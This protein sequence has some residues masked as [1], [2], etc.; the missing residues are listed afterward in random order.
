[1]SP[2]LVVLRQL[3][4]PSQEGLCTSMRFRQSDVH[5]VADFDSRDGFPNGQH[6]AGA[7][8]SDLVWKTMQDV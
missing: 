5:L 8:V 1:M 7:V 2:E 3:D 6:D 4:V